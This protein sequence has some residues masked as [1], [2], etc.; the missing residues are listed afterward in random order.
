MSQQLLFELNGARVA[1]DIATFGGTSYQVAN[2]GSVR[3]ERRK[4]SNPLAIIIFLL[5]LGILAVAIVNS[6]MTGAAEA[7]FSMAVTGVAVM[8]AAFFLQLIWPGRVY[9]LVLRTSS[10]DVDAVVSRKKEFVS[11][12]QKA[13]E[14]AFILR[15]RQPPA[16]ET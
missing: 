1:P 3:V 15:A 13:L 5:G 6:R 14:Q 12:I 2:I 8:V 9:V 4:K 10:G 7:Y 11:N 16:S